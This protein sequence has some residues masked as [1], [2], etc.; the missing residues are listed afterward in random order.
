MGGVSGVSEN[1]WERDFSD[2]VLSSFYTVQFDSP[3]AVR[4]DEASAGTPP[5]YVIYLLGVL[6][7]CMVGFV[8]SKRIQ[9]NQGK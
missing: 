9:P 7:L 5:D 8:W 1:A 6:F 2:G 4:L 3:T